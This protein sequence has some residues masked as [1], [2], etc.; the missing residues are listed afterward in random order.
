MPGLID[1]NRST[2]R[3]R[4]MKW[5]NAENKVKKKV[6]SEETYFQSHIRGSMGSGWSQTSQQHW[7]QED[8][9]TIASKAEEKISILKFYTQPNCL[10]SLKVG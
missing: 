6:N 9:G 2:V 3:H 4:M 5:P 10:S 7:R 1:E 8:K